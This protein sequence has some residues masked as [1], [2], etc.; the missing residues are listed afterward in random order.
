MRCGRLIGAERKWRRAKAG[1]QRLGRT[2]D[3][4]QTLPGKGAWSACHRL[5][6][7]AADTAAAT[8][9]RSLY[10]RQYCNC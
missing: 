3:L 9:V 8:D 7:F 6:F 4:R 2:A 1:K 10:D 5:Q